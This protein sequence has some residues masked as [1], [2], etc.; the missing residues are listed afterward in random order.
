MKAYVASSP[1]RMTPKRCRPWRHRKYL[2]VGYLDSQIAFRATAY[3]EFA[4]ATA[5]SSAHLNHVLITIVR[6]MLRGIS[7]ENRLFYE[8]VSQDQPFVY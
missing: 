4:I 6:R 7:H 5:I 2:V 3:Y 8:P 1:S